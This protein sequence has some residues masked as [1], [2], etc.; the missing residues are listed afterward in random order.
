MKAGNVPC[1]RMGPAYRQ[2]WR[3]DGGVKALPSLFPSVLNRAVLHPRSSENMSAKG[4]KPSPGL[5]LVGMLVGKLKAMVLVGVDEDLDLPLASSSEAT[6]P[7]LLDGPLEGERAPLPSLDLCLESPLE[8]YPLKEEE[9]EELLPLK[10]FC[11]VEEW[12]S[13]VSGFSLA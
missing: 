10:E 8:L 1:Q 11:P 4:S 7:R 9:E 6:T 12:F 5:K 2:A 3:L 13:A